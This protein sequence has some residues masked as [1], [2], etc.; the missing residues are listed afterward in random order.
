MLYQYFCS[1]C[2]MLQS[3]E[4]GLRFKRLLFLTEW[5]VLF[6]YG[7][8]RQRL[9]FLLICLHYELTDQ[10]STANT[11]SEDILMN[12]HFS[13]AVIWSSSSCGCNF[14]VSEREWIVAIPV[15]SLL[16][17]LNLVFNEVSTFHSFQ[18]IDDFWG[19]VLYYNYSVL[20]VGLCF[21]LLF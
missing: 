4:L 17:R 13:S 14:W 21:I 16:I 10:L 11:G 9:R 12:L 20:F 19:C 2:Y 3:E 5:D 6:D 15:G 8:R 1:R 18:I 7:I